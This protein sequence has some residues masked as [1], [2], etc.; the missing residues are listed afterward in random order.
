MYL[1]RDITNT[2]YPQIGEELGGRNHST[3]VYGCKK[4]SQALADDRDLRQAI[5]TIRRKLN[6]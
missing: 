6:S 1:A 4:I 3:I 2:S 5:D